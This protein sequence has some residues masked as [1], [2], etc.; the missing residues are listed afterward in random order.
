MRGCPFSKTVRE[1]DGVW[2][3]VSGWSSTVSEEQAGDW[4]FGIWGVE[5]SK[6]EEK[7]ELEEL[8]LEEKPESEE[9]SKSEEKSELEEE[10]EWEKKSEAKLKID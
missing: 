5:A 2:A 6:S 4:G 10:F 9:K 3:E 7:F 1:A 8:G